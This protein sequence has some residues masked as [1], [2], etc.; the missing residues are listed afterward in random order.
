MGVITKKIKIN[1]IHPYKV[2]LINGEPVKTPLGIIRW[3]GT[4]R[5]NKAVNLVKEEYGEG[6]YFVDVETVFERYY[7]P[8][9]EFMKH[10]TKI[11]CE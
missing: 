5:G 3:H 2:E 10:A 4:L 7:M 8:V 6:H 11:Y 9:E 1:Y